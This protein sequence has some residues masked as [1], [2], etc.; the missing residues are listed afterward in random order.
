MQL[1]LTSFSG[2]VIGSLI[3]LRTPSSALRVGF[4]FFFV[5]VNL[6]FVLS[7]T[8]S[9][10]GSVL[11]YVIRALCVWGVEVCIECSFPFHCI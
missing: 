2:F 5:C 11:H 4:F 3:F 7:V 9:C 10:P 6:G 1:I 8:P